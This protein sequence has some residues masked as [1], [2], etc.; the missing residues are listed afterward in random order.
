MKGVP[1]QFKNCWPPY[2]YEFADLVAQ[3]EEQGALERTQVAQNRTR[4]MPSYREV[5]RC[6]AV[7]GWGGQYL[8]AFDHL[9]EA[10]NMVA[11]AHSLGLDA[12]WVTRKRGGYADTWR[13]RHNKGC[14]I[15]AAGLIRD[16][17][18]VF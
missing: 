1:A 18:S 5:T 3:K 14:A 15:I 17:I 9:C 4:L 2:A 11:L 13:Q 12:G 8:G 10:V 16:R 7:I 6:E